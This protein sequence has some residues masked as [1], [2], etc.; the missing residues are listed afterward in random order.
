MF[1]PGSRAWA[2]FINEAYEHVGPGFGHGETTRELD[3]D[4]HDESEMCARVPPTRLLAAD[5]AVVASH[6]Q[7]PCYT[8][9]VVRVRVPDELAFGETWRIATIPTTMHAFRINETPPTAI[10]RCHHRLA[11]FVQAQAQARTPSPAQP[12]RTRHVPNIR[13]QSQSEAG[14]ASRVE[15]GNEQPRRPFAEGAHVLGHW[16]RGRAELRV[17]EEKREEKKREKPSWGEYYTRYA[18]FLSCRRHTP[19]PL[20]R[21]F[22]T[23]FANH[24]H[25]TITIPTSNTHD[26]RNHRHHCPSQVKMLFRT[27]TSVAL[28]ACAASVS[29]EPK[30]YRLAMMP[31]LGQSLARRSTNGYQPEL[32]QCHDGDTCAEACGSEYTECASSG[33]ETHCYNP[34]VKQSC[35]AD[36]S[37]NSCDEG[38]YCTHDHALKTWCCPDNMDLAAC[39]A[40][41]SVAGGLESATPTSTSTSSTSTST[42]TSTTSTT[43]VTTSAAPTTTSTTEA[44]TTTAAPTT[45]T[46]APTTT[47]APATTVT[48]VDEETT[49]VPRTTSAGFTSAYTGFNST[50]TSSVPNQPNQS[51]TPLPPVASI[52]TGA[53]QPP[54]PSTISG[55]ATTSASALLLLAAGVIAL[56]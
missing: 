33:K 48:K 16:R 25:E 22:C 43:V 54:Q 13:S 31:V 35:C 32:S 37:G 2:C 5:F 55:A 51:K 11:C 17:E 42:S 41:Y 46:A 34:S 50:V 9:V 28:L 8:L 14:G 7:Q 21:I 29:A 47:K 1:L 45:T 10:K 24:P 4:T 19:S 27:A 53:P 6:V 49:T 18:L 39:A 30:P 3:G 15:A 44:P 40:A 26:A 38:Y 56:L 20:S 23:H 36:G 52:S 12:E